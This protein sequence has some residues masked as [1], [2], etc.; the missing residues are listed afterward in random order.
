MRYIKMFEDIDKVEDLQTL[1][2]IC[3]DLEDDGFDVFYSRSIGFKTSHKNHDVTRKID[4]LDG[5]EIN[6]IQ[7]QKI[8]WGDDNRILGK[9]DFAPSEIKDTIDRIKNYLGDRFYYVMFFSW[10]SGA[11]KYKWCGTRSL[12]DNDSIWKAI[13]I[14]DKVK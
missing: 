3:I 4:D 7:I 2:D 13:I 11:R 1:E 12:L 14:Y 5:K 9:I 8:R 10:D 6:Y